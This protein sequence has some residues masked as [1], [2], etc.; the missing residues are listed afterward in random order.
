MV[1]FYTRKRYIDTMKANNTAR[2]TCPKC[3]ETIQQHYKFCSQCGVAVTEAIH[4]ALQAGSVTR[5][6]RSPYKTIVW[7]VALLGVA[8]AAFEIFT[9]S[10]APAANSQQQQQ[11]PPQSTGQSVSKPE[12]MAALTLPT[13]YDELVKMGHQHMDN[14]DFVIAA[15]CYKRAL[16][17]KGDTPDIRVDFGA[18]LHEMGLDRR[19]IEEFNVVIAANPK[20][21]IALFNLGVVHYGMQTYDSAKF[22]WDKFLALE[23]TGQGA[24]VVHK[25]MADI[26]KK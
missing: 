7:S 24:D 21:T 25:M 18:C 17:M 16:V 8:Y 10:M 15:E 19:A 14:G 23:P 9:N 3:G 4:A 13:D 11:A 20:H 2:I 6:K 1:E 12:A 26:P 22:Y 5:S